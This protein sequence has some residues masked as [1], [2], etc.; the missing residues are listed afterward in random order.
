MN[1]ADKAR[2]I[3]AYNARLDEQGAVPEA[4][5]WA[6]RRHNVR[7]AVLAELLALQGG[8]LL[9]FGC[10]MADL[11]QF[12]HSRALSVRY[13]GVDINERLIDIAR[14]RAPQA[15]L[16]VADIVDAPLQRRFDFVVAS[17][18]HNVKMADNAA[19]LRDSL[20]AMWQLADR[21]VAINFLSDRV[22]YRTEDSHHSDPC[23]VLRLCYEKTNKVVLRND[24]MPF[25]F[26]VAL[27]K[28]D[29]FD[30]HSVV[31]PQYLH[32]VDE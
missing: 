32:L 7:F 25:E 26:T 5:G 28:K 18:V 10:G 31:Y 1:E 21:A 15:E 4:L 13:T 9:D 8:S 20:D 23:E 27:Y 24:Y 29:Q 2:V 3:A 22:A 6:R 30:P 16:L 19:F 17:G 11:H 12:L 14:Q